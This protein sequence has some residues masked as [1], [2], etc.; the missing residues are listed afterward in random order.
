MSLPILDV[1]IGICFIYL[2]L[3]LICTTV[4]EMIA[5][6]MKRRAE[7]LDRGIARLLGGDMD[8]KRRLYEHPMIRGLMAGTN[9]PVPSY[10]APATFATA[11]MDVL[12]GPGASRADLGAVREGVAKL[13]SAPIRVA[14]TALLDAPGM[15][16]FAAHAAVEKWFNDGMD[17]VSGWY[18]RNSQLWALGMAAVIT[19]ALNADTVHMAHM[20]W[21][22]PTLRAA[23]VEEAK[24]RSSKARPEELLPL[25]EYP[26]PQDPTASQPVNVPSSALSSTE[27]GLLDQLTGW[28]AEEAYKGG[29]PFG[30]AWGRFAAHWLGWLITAIAVSQGAPFWF[31][32]LNKFMRVRNTGPA[33]GEKDAA[34]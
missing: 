18:K 7:F 5:G 19:L 11:L 33:P 2:L 21:V 23:V 25:V 10:I 24:V 16:P 8:L 20:L 27:S 34:K 22:S 9:D 29:N 3:S 12:S 1:A 6:W 13:E 28:S 15:D 17:R 4:N 30:W 14:I 31:D 32:T 26:D